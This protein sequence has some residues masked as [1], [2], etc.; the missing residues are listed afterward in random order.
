MVVG[1]RVIEKERSHNGRFHASGGVSPQKHLCGFGSFAPVRAAVEPPPSPICLPV[2]CHFGSAVRL[3]S[4][5][6]GA[7]LTMIATFEKKYKNE[8]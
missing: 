3:G 7:L 1:K 5:E 6:N 2:I 8:E 4:E